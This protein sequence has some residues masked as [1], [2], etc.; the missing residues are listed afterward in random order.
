MN[1]T[2]QN[3]TQPPR[4][5]AVVEALTGGIIGALIGGITSRFNKKATTSR[6][7][8]IGAGAGAALG[9]IMNLFAKKPP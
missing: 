8:A 7:I 2:Q 6:Q 3:S 4:R 9:V 1:D 5:S